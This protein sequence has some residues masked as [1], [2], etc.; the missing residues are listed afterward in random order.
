MP[1]FSILAQSLT[2]GTISAPNDTSVVHIPSTALNP[3][4]ISKFE[5]KQQL[6]D[7]V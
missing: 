4:S 7:N 1:G 5:T 2:S 6:V 3:G